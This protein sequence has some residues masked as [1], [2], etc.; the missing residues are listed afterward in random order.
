MALR[1]ASRSESSSGRSVISRTSSSTE[2]RLQRDEL[3]DV[4]VSADQQHA[5]QRLSDHPDEVG[6]DHHA[7]PRD[8]VGDHPSDEQTRHERDD[9]RGEHEAETGRRP[10]EIEDCE[11][12]RH[13]DDAVPEQR[14]DLG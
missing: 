9:P 13:G 7:P 12:Q 10:G 4:R 6:G 14:A 1:M 2:Y 8:A 11:G 3:P 5:Q